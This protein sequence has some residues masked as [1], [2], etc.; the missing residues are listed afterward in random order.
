M[1]DLTEHLEAQLRPDDAPDHPTEGWSITGL[2]TAAWASRKAAAARQQQAR[3]KAWADAEKAR[4]DAVAASEAARFERDAA[5][6]EAHLAAYLRSEIAAG[7]KTKSLEL[8][9]GTIS[10]RALQPR[11]TTADDELLAWAKETGRAELVRVT[12]KEALDKK[13][14]TKAATLAD[15]GVVVIDGEIVPGATWEAQEDNATFTVA[16]DAGEGVTA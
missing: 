14:L 10:L 8:P 11:I 3:V 15:D 5:F 6:F 13:A 7:R 16:D 9:G 2:E 4:V 1:T 12:V